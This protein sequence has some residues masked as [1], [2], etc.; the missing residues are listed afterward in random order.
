M[1]T[2]SP[3]QAEGSSRVDSRVRDLAAEIRRRLTGLR[4]L[5]LRKLMELDLGDGATLVL[6]LAPRRWKG[7]WRIRLQDQQTTCSE[8]RKSARNIS[9]SF[10]RENPPTTDELAL[11]LDEIRKVH[12]TSHRAASSGN[13]SEDSSA[14]SGVIKVSMP[15][16]KSG[17]RIKLLSPRDETS[18]KVPTPEQRSRIKIN[19][20]QVTVTPSRVMETE[21]KKPSSGALRNLGS[22]RPIPAMEYRLSRAV[23][24]EVTIPVRICNLLINHCRLSLEHGEEVGGV[25]IGYRE[26]E[27]GPSGAVDIYRV[28]A[29]DLI[30]FRA[31][32]SSGSRLHLTSDSW[33]HVNREESAAGFETQNKVRLGWYHTHPT[34]GIFFSKY[35]YDFHSVFP[36]AFQFAI[37]IDPRNMEAGLFYWDDI[38]RGVL[39][40]SKTFLLSPNDELSRPTIAV[41]NHNDD[42][43]VAPR[44]GRFAFQRALFFVFPALLV[45]IATSADAYPYFLK[46]GQII[47]LSLIPL[48]GLGLWSIHWFHP[49]DA[50]ERQILTGIEQLVDRTQTSGNIPA[51]TSVRGFGRG[52]WLVAGA[53]LVFAIFWFFGAPAALRKLRQPNPTAGP[54]QPVAADPV[55]RAPEGSTEERTLSLERLASDRILLRSSDG[56]AQ[57]RYQRTGT[58]WD[59]DQ[60]EEVDF[61]RRFFEWDVRKGISQL[62][63]K[64]LQVKL[65]PSNAEMYEGEW[66]PKTRKM[67]LEKIQA[68]AKNEST[69]AMRGAGNKTLVVRV[70]NSQSDDTASVP[71]LRRVT[72]N[73]KD[74]RTTRLTGRHGATREP[75]P[76]ATGPSNKKAPVTQPPRTNSGEPSR[77]VP[78]PPTNRGA[79]RATTKPGTK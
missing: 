76:P 14:G 21:D 3:N 70:V 56:I 20:A 39:K 24:V 75:K 5:S 48:I 79:Q 58:M 37:V 28:R 6:N 50:L 71:P 13:P 74:P 4:R 26:E 43:N 11:W 78:S 16:D 18:E 8:C 10:I 22:V 52:G 31:A 40:S 7:G 1:S 36:N 49:T 46:P 60:Q 77:S 54:Q 29:S 30:H 72:T 17:A 61:F 57:V 66:G 63:I 69:F 45:V 73:R 62:Y 2:V 38:E 41:V 33:A 68:L 25:M 42:P 34:Q 59:C 15:D 19:E 12:E 23:T 47:V 32:D 51:P 9:F 44:R 27:R 64:D 67:F 65:G 53:L 35:D 55:N